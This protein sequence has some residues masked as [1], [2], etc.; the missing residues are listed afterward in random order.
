[1]ATNFVPDLQVGSVIVPQRAG[2]DL[3]MEFEPLEGGSLLRMSDGSL[4]KVVIWSGKTAAR[5]RG[6]GRLPPSLQLLDLS[7]SH[8]VKACAPRAVSSATNTVTI[9]AARRT[10]LSSSVIG[11]AL[12]DGFG[13]I[14]TEVVSVIANVVTLTSVAGAVGY[15]A[16]YF[17]QFT[18]FVS[19]LGETYDR[20]RAQTRWSLRVTEA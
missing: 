15:Q 2:V 11:V 18:A 9:P 8:V 5:V 14:E 16:L 19:D 20:R 10:D 12:L 4:K 1:M 3:T 7:S 13:A 17:P 6:A